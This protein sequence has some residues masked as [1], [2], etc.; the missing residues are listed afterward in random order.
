MQDSVR[1]RTTQL[2]EQMKILQ[3]QINSLQAQF[4]SKR[5]KVIVKSIGKMIQVLRH[6][7]N[8]H[9]SGSRREM[10]I[11]TSRSQFHL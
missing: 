6:W 1:Q 9:H 10:H 8:V 3:A 4:K 2:Q 5:V 7:R 11:L